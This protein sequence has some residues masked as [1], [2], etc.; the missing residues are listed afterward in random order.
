MARASGGRLV[1]RALK[2]ENVKYVFSVP[3][4]HI[5]P[6]YEGLIEEGIEIISMRHEQGAGTR[7][8]AGL[9]SPKLPVSVL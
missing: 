1:A 4:G 6:I 7:R 9:E 8:M 5:S 3:G 2:A